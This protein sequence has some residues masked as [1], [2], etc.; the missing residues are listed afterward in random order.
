MEAFLSTVLIALVAALALS[1]ADA[2][3]RWSGTYSSDSGDSGSAYVILKQSGSTIT[4]TGGPD[5][6]EQW[7]LTNGKITGNKVTGEV[8]NP[9]GTVYKIELTLEGDS[10]K[11]PIVVTMPD[12]RSE[13]ARLEFTRVK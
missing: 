12:G 3:G 6:G 7:P 8:K 13:K 5:A 1:A 11:G 4:G 9:N 2:S 10:L